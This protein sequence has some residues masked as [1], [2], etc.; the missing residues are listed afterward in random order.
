M[1]SLNQKPIITN[2]ARKL[3][4]NQLTTVVTRHN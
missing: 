1:V 4:I 3:F 2:Q